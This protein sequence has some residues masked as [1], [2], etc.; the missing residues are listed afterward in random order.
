[1]VPLAY[2]VGDNGNAFGKACLVC[3]PTVSQR[4]W[5]D[6]PTLGLTQCFMDNKCVDSGDFLFCQRR[7]WS[8][9][10]FSKCQVCDPKQDIKPWSLMEEFIVD[11]G[12]SP[13]DECMPASLIDSSVPGGLIKSPVPAPA[14]LPMTDATVPP[15]TKA[16]VATPSKSFGDNV[17]DAMNTEDAMMFG[18]E[19]GAL[20]NYYCRY[21]DWMYRWSWLYHCRL[22]LQ[23]AQSWEVG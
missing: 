5:T 13:P 16:H 3:N 14:D 6:G 8:A 19:N 18:M 21:C 12:K 4:E 22:R 20:W 1:M 7:T 15:S 17:E 10:I 11:E 23:R 9:K 2:A